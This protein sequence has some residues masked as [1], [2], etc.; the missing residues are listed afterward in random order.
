MIIPPFVNCSCER[1]IKI[2]HQSKWIYTMKKLPDRLT[3]I[4][5]NDIMSKKK[6]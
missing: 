6:I 5:T 3:P 2:I 1:Y 4:F